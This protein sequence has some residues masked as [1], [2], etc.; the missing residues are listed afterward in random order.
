MGPSFSTF[1][2]DCLI[3]NNSI[4][5][6]GAGLHLLPEEILYH[7]QNR[8]FPEP[9]SRMEPGIPAPCFRS[10]D[11]MNICNLPWELFDDLSAVIQHAQKTEDILHILLVSLRL[12]FRPSAHT[13]LSRSEYWGSRSLRHNYRSRRSAVRRPQYSRCPPGTPSV[14]RPAPVSPGA[15]AA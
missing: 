2:T 12:R 9:V 1:R 5:Q 13:I 15:A 6:C 8:P 10:V 7:T 14:W 4:T 11:I 3:Q